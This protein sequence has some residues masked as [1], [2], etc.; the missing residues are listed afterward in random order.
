MDIQETLFQTFT[1]ALALVFAFILLQ[2]LVYIL[3]PVYRGI[4]TVVL[5][6]EKEAPPWSYKY[7]YENWRYGIPGPKEPL[8]P[9]SPYVPG[10]GRVY[11]V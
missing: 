3:T 4:I 7:R 5:P 8:P 11:K 10:V 1:V 2:T 9:S 6:P